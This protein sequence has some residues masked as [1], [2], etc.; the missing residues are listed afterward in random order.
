MKF[1]FYSRLLTFIF[2]IA[3]TPE[4]QAVGIEY[5]D[6]S[7]IDQLRGSFNSATQLTVSDLKSLNESKWNCDMYGMSTRLQ[8]EKNVRLYYFQG[9]EKDGKIEELQ[10]RGAQVVTSYRIGEALKGTKGSLSDEIR[11]SNDGKL[12]SR[13]EIESPKTKTS[14]VLAISVCEP[15]KI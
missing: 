12:I 1:R 3:I 11:R 13:L 5:L 4:A 14:R 8:V 6:N 7:R 10:N 9:V 15:L 2:T